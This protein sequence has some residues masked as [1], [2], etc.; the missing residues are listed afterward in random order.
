MDIS[1][2]SKITVKIG[3]QEFVLSKEDAESLYAGLSMALNKT[4]CITWNS[5]NTWGGNVNC[6]NESNSANTAYPY[7]QTK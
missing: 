4:S 3:D 1:V 5:G 2:D 7:D 6:F